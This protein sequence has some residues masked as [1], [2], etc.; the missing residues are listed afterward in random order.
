MKPLFTTKLL[1]TGMFEA[2]KPIKEQF[3]VPA[4]HFLG[5]N[6]TTF[7]NGSIGVT[8]GSRE[9]HL[10]S[11][12]SIGLQRVLEGGDR[13]PVTQPIVDAI[14]IETLRTYNVSLTL[15]QFHTHVHRQGDGEC[16]EVPCDCTHVCH[17]SWPQ[18][19]MADLLN[20]MRR[21]DSKNSESI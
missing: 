9:P 19:V 18:V 13:N 6:I 16:Y 14:G 8:P 1:S 11:H 2:S 15:E 3:C 4:G 7:W 5:T 10:G 12:R 17:P 20:I 21:L